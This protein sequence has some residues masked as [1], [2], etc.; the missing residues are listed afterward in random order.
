MGA[1]LGHTVKS[2]AYQFKSNDKNESANIAGGIINTARKVTNMGTTNL[3]T[4]SLNTNTINKA[5]DNTLKAEKLNSNVINKN[6]FKTGITRAYNVSKDVLKLGRYMADGTKL[7][8]TQTSNNFN[9]YNKNDNFKI[10]KKQDGDLA[11]THNIFNT[12]K[13]DDEDD[14]ND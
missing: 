5:N 4:S 10:S 12:I 9:K 14:A 1:A 13:E 7:H 8:E 6:N 2:I 3:Q 11:A